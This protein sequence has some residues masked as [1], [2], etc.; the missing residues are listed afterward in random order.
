MRLMYH[1]T[2][3]RNVRDLSNEIG[4]N[5]RFNLFSASK[6]SPNP[7][8]VL[9]CSGGYCAGGHRDA[10]SGESVATQL[11]PHRGIPGWLQFLWKRTLTSQI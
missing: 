7:R 8:V 9:G 10:W 1:L 6:W 5:S 11:M 2:L 3:P 4:G